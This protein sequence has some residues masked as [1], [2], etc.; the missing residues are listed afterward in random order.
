MSWQWCLRWSWWEPRTLRSRATV[1]CAITRTNHKQHRLGSGR[2]RNIPP[3]EPLTTSYDHALATL[4]NNKWHT[5]PGGAGAAA[6]A[7]QAQSMSCVVPYQML[8]AHVAACSAL[9]RT[10]SRLMATV[11]SRG[12]TVQLAR[13]RQ[14]RLHR[15]G[16]YSTSADTRTR[17]AV[18]TGLPQNPPSM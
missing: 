17:M 16:E 15:V 7:S 6:T 9:R 12:W 18:S 3:C 2:G 4:L 10:L 8:T 1:A 14:S 11:T 5:G 13:A